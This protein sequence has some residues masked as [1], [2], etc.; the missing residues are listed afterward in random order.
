M[1]KNKPKKAKQVQ[2]K[3]TEPKGKG[4]PEKGKQVQK[5]STE[6]KGKGTNPQKK[7]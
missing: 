1:P 7:K 6:T 4:K 2:K 5:K 3:T